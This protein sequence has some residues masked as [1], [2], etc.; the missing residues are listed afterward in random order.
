MRVP[1]TY[2]HS[3]RTRRESIGISS[4]GMPG[5]HCM[6]KE[7]SDLALMRESADLLDRGHARLYWEY[8]SMSEVRRRMDGFELAIGERVAWLRKPG[9]RKGE[10]SAQWH[11]SKISGHM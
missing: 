9:S 2:F 4:A 11:L 10:Q 1:S 7:H 6:S 8:A 5:S 3:V